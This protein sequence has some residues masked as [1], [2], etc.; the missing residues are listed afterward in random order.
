[1]IQPA[2]SAQELRRKFTTQGIAAHRIREHHIAGLYSK[3]RSDPDRADFTAAEPLLT[4]LHEGGQWGMQPFAVIVETR[5]IPELQFV[6]ENIA[7]QTQL[8]I[9]IIHGQKNRAILDTE[10]VKTLLLDARCLP[11][12]LP[13][14]ALQASVYN[15]LFLDSRFYRSLGGRGKFLVFQTDSVCCTCSEFALEN[16]LNFDYI[17]AA[18]PRHRP[19]GLHIDGGC[20][21]FSIRDW[22]ASFAAV[23]RFSTELWP[24][25]EDGFFAFHLDLMGGKVADADAMARFATQSVFQYRSFGAHQVRNL[26]PQ[27]HARFL[28]YCPEIH[29]VLSWG[30]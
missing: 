24:G 8:P 7:I 1:M 13:T 4:E 18:W 9:Q 15:A 20:G 28:E 11:I 21:G 23:E 29:R 19:V 2:S 17:G 5:D 14:D 3:L 6:I 30:R 27:D 26:R 25:G 22:T 10:I 16:F 12:E